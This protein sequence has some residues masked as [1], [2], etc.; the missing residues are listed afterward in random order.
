MKARRVV[1]GFFVCFLV[2]SSWAFAEEN[3]HPEAMSGLQ[4]LRNYL[5]QN[6]S[7]DSMVKDQMALI[8]Q[9]I[10]K[11]EAQ[12]TADCSYLW[13]IQPTIEG[14]IRLLQAF[15]LIDGT[16]PWFL[17]GMI[18]DSAFWIP[19]ACDCNNDETGCINWWFDFLYNALAFCGRC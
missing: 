16:C 3:Y 13:E 9:E 5:A 17:V 19:L 14:V 15:I 4:L 8:D 2:F 12:E 6:F 1:I 18:V 10:M 11:L 7:D